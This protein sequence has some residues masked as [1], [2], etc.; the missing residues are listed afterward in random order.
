[1]DVVEDKDEEDNSSQ[2]FEKD[3]ISWLLKELLEKYVPQ[4]HPNVRQVGFYNFAFCLNYKII[5]QFLF[6]QVNGITSK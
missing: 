6:Y 3:R 5:F 1:M 4:S 2:L